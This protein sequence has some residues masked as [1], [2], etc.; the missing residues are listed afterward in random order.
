MDLS[1][2]RDR[3]LNMFGV[4]EK[5]SDVPECVYGCQHSDFMVKGIITDDSGENV[6]DAKVKATVYPIGETPSKKN[7]WEL[8][9][10]NS[11]ED[12]QY[13]IASSEFFQGN[14]SLTAQKDGYTSSTT[15]FEVKEE[16]FKGGTGRWDHG[17][18]TINKD[19][20]LKK[21]K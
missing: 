1:D 17:E 16:D 7:G 11:N 20:V 6:C 12:G 15:N 21:E 10:S 8:G 14:V 9:I 18:C 2:I 4:K 3:L 5:P 13:E 19:M